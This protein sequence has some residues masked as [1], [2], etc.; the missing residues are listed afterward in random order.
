MKSNEWLVKR[1]N[2]DIAFAIIYHTLDQKQDPYML[3]GTPT[4]LLVL[5][6]WNDTPEGHAY[7]KKMQL[8][9][10]IFNL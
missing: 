4:S 9:E 6:N 2:E 1:F 8:T 3:D 7:W 10:T 5:F